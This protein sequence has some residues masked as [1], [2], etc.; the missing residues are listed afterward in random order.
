MWI[1]VNC[2]HSEGDFRHKACDF[3]PKSMRSIERKTHRL[4][5]A[6]GCAYT[7]SGAVHRGTE[8]RNEI[9]FSHTSGAA[10]PASVAIEELLS[11]SVEEFLSKRLQ[12][13]E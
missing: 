2:L 5:I 4:D 8:R 7:S 12:R 13:K 3:Y 10:K 1:V 9:R 6:L 11:D